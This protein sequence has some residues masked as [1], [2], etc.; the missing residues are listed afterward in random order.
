MP[1]GAGAFRFARGLC[2]LCGAFAWPYESEAFS[3]SSRIRGS[4]RFQKNRTLDLLLLSRN[5][6]NGNNE[7]YCPILEKI[8]KQFPDPQKQGTAEAGEG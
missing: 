5:P 3:V 7:K 6:G 2:D 8:N 1:V 4:T